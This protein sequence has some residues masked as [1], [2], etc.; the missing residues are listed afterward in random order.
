MSTNSRSRDP[1]HPGPH[2]T[3]STATGRE[4]LMT[5]CRSATGT[6]CRSL[7]RQRK[8]RARHSATSQG[9]WL[10]P[11]TSRHGPLQPI[12]AREE[13]LFCSQ[14]GLTR[15]EA[16]CIF[17]CSNIEPK[18]T[19]RS[20]VQARTLF[21]IPS[22]LKSLVTEVQARPALSLLMREGIV[23]H[24]TS[25]ST[26]PGESLRENEVEERGRKRES[27]PTRHYFL[28]SY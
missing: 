2:L 27:S 6:A 20:A 28:Y 17:C 13:D 3:S 7:T 19:L 10:R 12:S 18:P 25:Q 22:G 14:A 4:R 16:S 23:K 8:E 26:G 21:R 24:I 5:L 1:H 15:G 11:C 9:C